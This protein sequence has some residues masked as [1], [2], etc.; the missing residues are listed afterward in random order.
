MNK[1][2]FESH[3]RLIHDLKIFI[4]S[5]LEFNSLLVRK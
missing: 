5:Y 1:P 4:I 3:G 2:I